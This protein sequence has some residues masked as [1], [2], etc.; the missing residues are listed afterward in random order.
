MNSN[1]DFL[2]CTTN[3]TDGIVSEAMLRD[4]FLKKTEHFADEITQRCARLDRRADGVKHG[5]LQSM[6]AARATQLLPCFQS[7]CLTR[8]RQIQ[9]QR[10]QLVQ[11]LQRYAQQLMSNKSLHT[12]P[13][14]R[15]GG[16][17]HDPS[18]GAAR[19]CYSNLEFVWGAVE[20]AMEREPAYYTVALCPPTAALE[21][22][23]ME[24]VL[25]RRLH[26][27]LANAL[28]DHTTH[29]AAPFAREEADPN[30]TSIPNAAV[31]Q[32]SLRLLLQCMRHTP[33]A[34]PHGKP[35]AAA[36]SPMEDLLDTRS[37]NEEEDECVMNGEVD[38]VDNNGRTL[39]GCGIRADSP[40]LDRSPCTL[41]LPLFV[42]LTQ[43]CCDAPWVGPGIPLTDLK[44]KKKPPR[45]PAAPTEVG[46]V[47]PEYL[48]HEAAEEDPTLG[49]LFSPLTRGAEHGPGGPRFPDR[50]HTTATGDGDND[51]EEPQQ[52]GPSFQQRLTS[53]VVRVLTRA[54]DAAWACVPS[55]VTDYLTKKGLVEQLT[56][57]TP[58][59]ASGDDKDV[60]WCVEQ[61][62]DV[63]RIAYAVELAA[64]VLALRTS[65]QVLVESD[66][67]ALFDAV[68]A[69]S[70]ILVAPCGT[71]TPQDPSG[72]GS[73]L[74][75]LQS[76]TLPETRFSSLA[77]YFE[78]AG[79]KA[80]GATLVPMTVLNLPGIESV[81]YCI[82][83]TAGAALLCDAT[84]AI[85][86]AAKG[87][88]AATPINVD[89]PEKHGS[90]HTGGGV[91][92]EC[93]KATVIPQ[94]PYNSGGAIE[95]DRIL[96][97]R[98]VE[99]LGQVMM[100]GSPVF[101]SFARAQRV[102]VYLW[103]NV[104]LVVDSYGAE[105]PPLQSASPAQFGRKD[106]NIERVTLSERLARRWVCVQTTAA[107]DY[108]LQRVFLICPPPLRYR[109]P[110][111]ESSMNEN[112]T[113]SELVGATA[114]RME[115]AMMSMLRNRDQ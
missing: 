30:G 58:D 91:N 62:M 12:T 31:V 84:A 59:D 106:G 70:F 54:V 82:A 17:Q 22:F 99:A 67:A 108:A 114:R 80:I 27:K 97:K 25:K 47:S 36:N 89:I 60:F 24:A 76:G 42:S 112:S 95:W 111:N 93:E 104:F 40:S 90:F 88:D 44:E 92:E 75:T 7:I 69:S 103:E 43:Y 100:G 49:F 78:G 48:G 94:S 56:A 26:E 71:T 98:Y 57:V 10:S 87:L 19:S 68:R 46:Q 18:D 85:Q 81:F 50:Y 73:T 41:S 1:S 32:E 29:V 72:P 39:E 107:V 13:S 115:Q 79:K 2:Q 45:R 113:S 74:D 51:S 15:A 66:T 55:T 8:A 37:L 64:R 4:Y 105:P 20:A 109:G 110:H 63:L 86:H 101:L 5:I 77:E 21:D 38:P 61:L 102:W 33:V 23:I 3:F 35:S 9:Q 6:V 53:E 11:A 34:S 52:A 14:V 96:L 28:E 65:M 83:Y 16:N